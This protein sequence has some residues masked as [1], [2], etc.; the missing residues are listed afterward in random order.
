MKPVQQALTNHS[1]SNQ[2]QQSQTTPLQQG[3]N[4]LLRQPDRILGVT[5]DGLASYPAW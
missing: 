2:T 3:T 4:E 1:L 5:C